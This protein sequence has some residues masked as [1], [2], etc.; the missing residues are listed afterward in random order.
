L[1]D[2]NYADFIGPPF[3]WPPAKDASLD[4]AL[5]GRFDPISLLLVRHPADQLA[6]LRSHR[7]LQLVLTA[8]RFVAGNLAFLMCFRSA[9]VFRYEEL[10]DAPEA[11]FRSMCERLDFPFAH[12]ALTEFVHVGAVTGSLTRAAESQ[13]AAA[14]PSAEAAL[15]RQ[16]LAALPEY[17]E[18]LD[19]LGYRA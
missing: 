19:R 11:S 13:I 18:L 12:A 9:P 17:R 3:V 8:E 5:A 1:R 2:F 10:L 7:A 16:E 14:A 15:A 4:A 6:S